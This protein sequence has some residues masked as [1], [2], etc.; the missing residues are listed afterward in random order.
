[1]PDSSKEK[2]APVRPQ[3]IWMSSTISSMSWRSHSS[4][5]ARSHSGRATLIPPSPCTVSTI[6]AAGWLRPEPWS[7]SSRSN[8]RKS[9]I[10]PSK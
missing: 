3:P 7:S 9:G 2:K 4:A 1:M 6:T 8:H 10:V 5:R